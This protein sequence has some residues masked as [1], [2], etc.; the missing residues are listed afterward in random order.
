MPPPVRYEARSPHHPCDVACLLCCQ[1]SM[2][3]GYADNST[4]CLDNDNEPQPDLF[5]LLPST[6]GGKSK[7]DEDDYVSGPPSLV[8]EVAAS[9]VSI[10]L[11]LKKTAYRRNGVQEYL[12]WRTEDA[13]IDWFTLANGVFVPLSP[14]ADG[15]LRSRIFP[16]LWLNPTHLLN[17]DLPALLPSSIA[18]CLHRMPNSSRSYLRVNAPRIAPPHRLRTQVRLCRG[19]GGVDGPTQGRGVPHRVA[20]VGFGAVLDQQAEHRHVVIHGGLVDRQRMTVDEQK[21][22]DVGAGREA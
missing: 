12:V 9:S 7:I 15:T 3:L 20:D 22:V 6:L 4:V 19:F 14:A 13:A 5:L 8:C 21:R 16:G 18:A 11:H 2:S 1:D 10:D 17:A